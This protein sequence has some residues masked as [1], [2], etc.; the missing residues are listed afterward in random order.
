MGNNYSINQIIVNHALFIKP[1]LMLFNRLET[2][3]DLI[4]IF[5][6]KNRVRVLTS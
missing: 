4:K 5:K 1:I 6:K 2:I 3:D